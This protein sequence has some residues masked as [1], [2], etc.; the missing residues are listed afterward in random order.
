M[1]DEREADA[2]LAHA[3]R[4]SDEVRARASKRDQQ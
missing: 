2:A 3:W 4:A 1:A